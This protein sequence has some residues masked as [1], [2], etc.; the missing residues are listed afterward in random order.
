V[1]HATRVDE[2]LVAGRPVLIGISTPV[3]CVSLVCGP[4]TEYLVDV[5]GRF[6]D[7]VDV[8]HIEVW[9]DFEDRQLNPAAAA[10]ILPRTGSDGRE[11]WVFLVDGTGTV[12]ARWDNVLDP[13]EL[14]AALSALPVLGDA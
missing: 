11:P 10:W 3:Y 12:I 1:L 9:E 14:E 4:L 7:R 2:A 6:G 5:A 13:V 8:V